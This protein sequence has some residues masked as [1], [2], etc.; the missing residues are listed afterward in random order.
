MSKR[1]NLT[2]RIQ[3]LGEQINAIRTEALEANMPFVAGLVR[4]AEANLLAAHELIA[5]ARVPDKEL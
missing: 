3:T 5:D 1:V 2:N 4:G